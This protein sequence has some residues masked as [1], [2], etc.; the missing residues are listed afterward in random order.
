MRF[1]IA[2]GFGII[3]LVAFVNAGLI[4]QTRK[5]IDMVIEDEAHDLDS[6]CFYQIKD[7]LIKQ[8]EIAGAK[9]V[10]RV[11]NDT[12]VFK[13]GLRLNMENFIKE[14]LPKTMVTA[15]DDC[16]HLVQKTL[17]K[18]IKARFL[19]AFKKIDPYFE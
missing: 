10:E 8:L 19:D 18:S 11:E 6:D 12:P 4:E 17:K 14:L 5:L 9:N 2:V 16:L 3:L 13:N 15:G 1:H 7:V